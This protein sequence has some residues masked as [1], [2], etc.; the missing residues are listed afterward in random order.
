MCEHS[1][2]SADDCKPNKSLRT[3]IRVFI[4]TEEKKR[5]ALRPKESVEATPATPSEPKVPSEGRPSASVEAPP[6]ETSTKTESPAVGAKDSRELSAPAV[7]DRVEQA[8]A[9]GET[10][11]QPAE[12]AEKV[13]AH[14]WPSRYD[15]LT[16]YQDGSTLAQE[17]DTA[18]DLGTL[19][20]TDAGPVEQVSNEEDVE[21]A[22]GTREDESGKDKE[23]NFNFN[24]GFGFDPTNGPF[25][26][27]NF[28]GG[29][30]FN[31]MQ[32]MLAM[33]SGMG[34]NS[35]GGFPMMGKN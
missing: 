22:T 16:L 12:P 2:L 30:D 1:P 29:A 6:V 5:E 28:G 13:R 17:P 34:P 33:Q 3:T 32:I 19:A 25:P 7:D 18:Q 20:S 31:Q 14:D 21:Q 8:E 10:A 24:A 4:R 23:Q 9:A 11:G 35:F 26:S 15:L 27:V